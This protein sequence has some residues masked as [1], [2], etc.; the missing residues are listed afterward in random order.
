MKYFII[1]GTSRGLGE[2]IAKKL[3]Q[4]GNHLFCISRTENKKL[5]ML[6]KKKKTT[7]NYYKFNL[8]KVNDIEDLMK[9]IF[10][11]IDGLQAQG[12]YLV[13]NAGIVEPIKPIEGCNSKDIVKNLNTNL[14]APMILSSNFIKLSEKMSMEK[15]I[16]NISS[17]AAHFPIHSWS[18]YCSSKAGLRMFTQT[19]ALEQKKAIYPVKI[20]SIAPGIVDTSMQERTRKTKKQDFPDVDEFI[21]YKNQGMLSSPDAT[22]DRIVRIMLFGSIKQGEEYS[23]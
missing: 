16:I 14:I 6:A 4:S 12:I 3:L 5:V 19:V 9:K 13:N 17:G 11:K 18:A 1:T 20:A 23:F 10:S 15:R 21:R 22:A 2:G 7:I 8:N